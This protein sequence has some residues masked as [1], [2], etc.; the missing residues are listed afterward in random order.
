[1]TEVLVDAVAHK[2]AEWEV[3]VLGETLAD[4]KAEALLYALIDTVR[5]VRTWSREFRGTIGHAGSH[6]G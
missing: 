5:T 4:L 6:T 2:L 1:M 3:A